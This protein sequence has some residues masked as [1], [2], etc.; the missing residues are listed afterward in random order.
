MKPVQF[1]LRL[2]FAEAV[3]INSLS[4]QIFT[5]LTGE[6]PKPESE[7]IVERG[8]RVQVNED[9][10]T[11]WWNPTYCRI[12]LEKISDIP[13]VSDKK[14]YI[15][16]IISVLENIN[17]VAKIGKLSNKI[18]I[19]HWILPTP[20]YDFVSLERKYKEL[21]VAKNDISDNAYDSS[22]IFDIRK[23]KWILHHQSGPMEPEQVQKQYLSFKLDNV[24]K[25][26]I[27]L[28]A[29]LTDNNVIQ[30]SR[31][32]VRSFMEGALENCISHMEEFN[33]I[34]EGCL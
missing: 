29:G 5:T 15:D 31:E 27:F 3:R 14:H 18:L 6:S 13:N 1:V 2:Q 26:F 10:M 28:E 33:R 23:D 17:E 8:V 12:A 21:M 20:Q 19:T 24:P 4:H 16:R 30:Y 32:E 34:C 22:T 9:K 25:T 7:L 11:I